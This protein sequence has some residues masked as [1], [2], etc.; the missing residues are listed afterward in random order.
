[1]NMVK[2]NDILPF[3]YFDLNIL[4]WNI[5]GLSSM[6][7][8]SKLNDPEVIDTAKSYDI[9]GIRETRANSNKNVNLEGFK[10]LSHSMRPKQKS[11]QNKNEKKSGRHSGGGSVLQ[12]EYF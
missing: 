5:H 3:S 2:K 1:M 4:A 9:I 6:A 12:T 10:L 7:Y 8:G 11:A